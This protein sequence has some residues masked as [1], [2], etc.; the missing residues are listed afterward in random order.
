MF[1]LKIGVFLFKPELVQKTLHL[2]H[3]GQE[4]CNDVYNEV[5]EQIQRRI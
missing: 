5:Q 4:N 3:V 2:L 1:Q